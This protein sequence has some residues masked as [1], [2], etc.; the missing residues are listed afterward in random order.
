MGDKW[1]NSQCWDPVA[2]GGVVGWGLSFHFW[3]QETLPPIR[4]GGGWDTHRN[5]L[6]DLQ[7][8]PTAAEVG[9]LLRD[10]GDRTWL[11]PCVCGGDKR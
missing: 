4:G 8:P 10:N 7:R 6:W 11:C 2:R 3:G 1:D 9:T 5:A